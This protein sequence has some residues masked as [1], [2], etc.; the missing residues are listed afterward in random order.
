MIDTVKVRFFKTVGVFVAIIV[1]FL[2]GF[3]FGQIGHKGSSAPAK[4]TKSHKAAKGSELNDAY[5]KDFLVA[6]YTKK[7]LGEN[8][9]RYKPFMTEGLYNGTVTEEEEPTNQAYKG[10]VVNFKFD[11]AQIYIDQ[12]DKTAIV[13]I[14]YTNDIYKTKGS[15]KDAQLDVDN[16]LTMKLSYTKTNGKYLLNDMSSLLIA[17]SSNGGSSDGTLSYGTVIPGSSSSSSSDTD[18]TTDTN[19][20]S[21]ND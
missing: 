15:K 4:Q 13:T 18:S 14:R 16:K 6:Y 5:I 17:D 3:S 19:T 10:Y 1:I 9:D 21:D 8:R 11:D 20:D 2:L 12:A 7:D